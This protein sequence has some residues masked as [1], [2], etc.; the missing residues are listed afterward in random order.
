[1]SR[2]AEGTEVS[3]EKS[4]A[5]I[6]RTITR[7]GGDLISFG[8]RD[9]R[10][11]VLGFRFRGRYAKFDQ[12]LPNLA[13]REFQ[14]TARGV[15][16]SPAQVKASYEAELRRRWRVLLIRLKVKFETVESEPELFEEE[17]MAHLLLPDGSTVM[18]W[19]QP[20]IEQA[21]LSGRMPDRMLLLPAPK[22]AHN[23]P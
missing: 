13:D 15:L 4:K 22:E 17:F 16:R 5:E 10:T 3:V 9:E 7:Y 8:W 19:I 21:Y 20:Q 2:Y 6:E 1:M 18:E 14:R 11:A 12:R 23:E